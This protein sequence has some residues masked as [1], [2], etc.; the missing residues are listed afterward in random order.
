MMLY[1]VVLLV[2][3]VIGLVTIVKL[4]RMLALFTNAST[5]QHDIFNMPMDMQDDGIAK[6]QIGNKQW[7]FVYKQKWAKQFLGA[8]SDSVLA[9]SKIAVFRQLIGEK[10]GIAMTF[11]WH[12]FPKRDSHMY[13]LFNQTN[14]KEYF[15]ALEGIVKKCIASKFDKHG[16]FDLDRMTA[17][18]TLIILFQML[19]DTDISACDAKQM[20]E[21]VT[22]YIRF[23]A[24]H[25]IKHDVLVQPLTSAER[26]ERTGIKAKLYN[27]VIG[28]LRTQGNK[29]Y[30]FIS[31][32]S[33]FTRIAFTIVPG[34]IDYA[35]FVNFYGA[36][37]NI[38]VNSFWAIYE[39]LKNEQYIPKIINEF[40]SNDTTKGLDTYYNAPTLAHCI[41]ES[42]RLHPEGRL[43]TRFIKKDTVMESECPFKRKASF[44]GNSFVMFCPYVAHRDESFFTN[45]NTYLPDRFQG[46]KAE[47]HMSNVKSYPFGHGKNMCTGMKFGF[48]TLRII[49]KEI[50]CHFNVAFANAKS[51]IVVEQNDSY[52]S[53]PQDRV[54]IEYSRKEN[55][56]KS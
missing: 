5:D 4:V 48:L 31:K 24:S 2:P 16:E 38:S 14:P 43:V 56:F 52:M 55:A 30:H 8:D 49:V 41:L 22:A 23:R 27:A 34:L 9:S 40:S 28:M 44:E 51:T 45:A 46:T 12:L 54:M 25:S 20:E 36:S 26:E 15:E 10:L 37:L 42:L 50:L 35:A 19:F 18:M 13:K 7:Y 47:K 33:F 6:K 32:A 39:L 3:L 29:H 17:E 21:L 11:L 53:C 1:L